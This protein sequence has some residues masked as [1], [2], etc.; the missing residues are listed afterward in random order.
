MQHPWQQ[1]PDLGVAGG[2]AG[3]ARL[4]TE[5]NFSPGSRCAVGVGNQLQDQR[6]FNGDDY[7]RRVLPLAT[8]SPLATSRSSAN[9]CVLLC[10]RYL[11]QSD[12]LRYGGVLR[13]P[14]KYAGLVHFDGDGAATAQQKPPGGS[15]AEQ[16]GVL[17]ANPLGDAMGISG[18]VN[19]LNKFA[20]HRQPRR[21]VQDLRPGQ[22]AVLPRH[23]ATCRAGTDQR[24]HR[25]QPVPPST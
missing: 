21:G 6:Q 4:A 8:T 24:L 19:Y 3:T 23:C 13:A 16:N 2:T 14:M 22:R 15:G 10:L 7:C 18:V 12:N 25:G 11:N 5:T 20:S 17:E 9:P 1:R